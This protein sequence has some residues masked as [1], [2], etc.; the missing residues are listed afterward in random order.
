MNLKM[1]QEMPGQKEAYPAGRAKG[2]RSYIHLV[3]PSH[4]TNRQPSSILVWTA[5]GGW[6]ETWEPY[7]LGRGG[8]CNLQ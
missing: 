2:E 7:G 8:G 5:P 1:V 3:S 6:T 4:T